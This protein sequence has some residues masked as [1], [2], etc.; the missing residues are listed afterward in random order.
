MLNVCAPFCQRCRS[1]VSHVSCHILTPLRICKIKPSPRCRF[2]S[3]RGS[4]QSDVLLSSVKRF[5]TLR[6]CV[7]K[8]C[9]EYLNGTGNKSQSLRLHEMSKMLSDNPHVKWHRSC[10]DENCKC[11]KVVGCIMV[12]KKKQIFIC[13]KVAKIPSN[14]PHHLFIFAILWLIS[15]FNYFNYSPLFVKKK[16]KF[17]M[18]PHTACYN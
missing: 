9:D 3:A 2:S 5:S 6:L 18:R 14:P 10:N 16:K 12:R 11:W 8:P 17:C 7:S 1:A 13:G 15:L 4:V